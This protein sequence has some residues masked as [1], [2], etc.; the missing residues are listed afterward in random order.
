[1]LGRQSTMN[2]NLGTGEDLAVSA[3]TEET[4]EHNVRNPGFRERLGEWERS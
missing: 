1:M 4:K 2:T 3:K